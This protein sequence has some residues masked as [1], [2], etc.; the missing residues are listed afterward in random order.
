MYQFV[1]IRS[2]GIVDIATIIWIREISHFCI[3]NVP[4]IQLSYLIYPSILVVVIG[5]RYCLLHM[6]G[7]SL[8]YPVILCCWYLMMRLIYLIISILLI[9]F[10]SPSSNSV[11]RTLLKLSIYPDLNLYSA[12]PYPSF[13]ANPTTPH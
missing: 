7:S 13:A 10:F 1:R 6:Q 12:L 3:L 9:T 8:S 4:E 5:L 11:P 2:H